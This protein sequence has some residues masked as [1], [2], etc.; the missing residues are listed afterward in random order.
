MFM[1]LGAPDTKSVEIVDVSKDSPASQA[2]MLPGDLISSVN[3]VSITSTDQLH[4]V[5][6]T[7]SGKQVAIVLTRAGKD[8]SVSLTPRVNPP[9]GQ[10]PTGITMGNPYRPVSLLEAIPAAGSTAFDQARE[11]FLLPVKLAQGTATSTETRVVG[12]IGMFDI[13]SQAVQLDSQASSA[14]IQQPAINVLWFVGTIAVALGLTN[15]LPIPALDGGRILF[16][17]P[18][19]LFRR[20]IPAQYENFV[21]VVGFMALILLMSYI[22]F[23]DFAHPILL[24]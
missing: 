11:L 19:L 16:L 12:P 23:Q 3:G 4:E 9:T 17:L 7:N 14:P 15:L 18:E 24:P 1:R 6:T 10:G 13:Y 20:R 5:I 8:I 2:G 22:T 21:N